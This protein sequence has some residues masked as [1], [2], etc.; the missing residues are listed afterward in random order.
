MMREPF[1]FASLVEHG[2]GVVLADVLAQWPDISLTLSG[3]RMGLGL[4]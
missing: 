3:R 2:G 4:T 1:R